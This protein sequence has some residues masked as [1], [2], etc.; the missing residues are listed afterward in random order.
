MACQISNE[1]SRWLPRHLGIYTPLRKRS[2]LGSH[3]P[4]QRHGELLR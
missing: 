3:S 4:Q 2:A 1:R